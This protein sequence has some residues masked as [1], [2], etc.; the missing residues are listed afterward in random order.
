MMAGAAH[1]SVLDLGHSQWQRHLQSVFDN[2]ISSRTA[3]SLEVVAAL[4]ASLVTALQASCE[5][6]R[7]GLHTPC[8]LP[9]PVPRSH[10]QT[11]RD[12]LTRSPPAHTI[13]H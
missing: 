6:C 2:Y 13:A 9:L 7:P 12:T 8:P 5:R 3:E 10:S 11:L 4:E 1:T